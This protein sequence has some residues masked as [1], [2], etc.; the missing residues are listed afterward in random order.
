MRL[1]DQGM[2]LMLVLEVIANLLFRGAR[3][4]LDDWV[5]SGEWAMYY[6][7]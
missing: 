6:Q 3:F 7:R 2:E 1:V 5:V 4:E